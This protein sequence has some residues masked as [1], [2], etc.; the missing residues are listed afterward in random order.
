MDPSWEYITY[1]SLTL[2]VPFLLPDEKVDDEA[3]RGNK[4]SA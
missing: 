3:Y 2:H 1:L 4:Y